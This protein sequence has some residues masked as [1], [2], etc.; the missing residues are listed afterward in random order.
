MKRSGWIPLLIIS[1]VIAV[2]VISCKT[3]F[4]TTNSDFKAGHSQAEIERGRVLVYSICA[5]CHYNRQAGKFIGNRIEDVPAIAG[6][7]YSANL[8][9]SKT[10]GL[11]EK[12]TDAQLKYLLKTGVAYDGRFIQYMLRPNMAEN[13]LDAVVAFLRSDDPALAAADTTVGP[14]HYTAMGKMYMNAHAKP[15]PYKTIATRPGENDPVALGKYLVDNLGCYHCHSKSLTSLNFLDPDQS[16]GYMAG[17]TVM[18]GENGSEVTAPNITPDNTTG[19][20][21]YTHEQFIKAI[22]D[23]ESPQMKLMPPMP[24][25]KLLS[26]ADVAAIYAYIKTIPPASHTIQMK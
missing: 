24:K 16:A 4:A 17:G 8:T 19:I 22:K 6:E 25:F 26:D 21:A 1:A 20:G 18:K 7:V 5:G 14:T 10:H 13:D 3:R 9:H 12:Y 15:L 11:P 23:G 2:V